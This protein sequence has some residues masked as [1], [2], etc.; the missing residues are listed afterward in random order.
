[1]ID[2]TFIPTYLGITMDPE[3]RFTRHILRTANKTLRKL[4]I[5]RKLR[6]STWRSRPKTVKNAFC[7]IIRPL[8]EYAAPIWNPSSQSSK[9]DSVQHRASKIIIGAV[10]ST[11]NN[12]AEQECGLP[13][14]ENRR[15]L[16]IIKFTN[17]LRS[18]NMDHISTRAFNEGKGSTRLKPQ[19]YSLIKISEV[20]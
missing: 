17:R 13:P 10:S 19:L 2:L 1:M 6:G 12:K 4:S 14:L 3:I 8:L 18:N 9:M 5:L 7:S 20:G 11:N 16:A 15:N